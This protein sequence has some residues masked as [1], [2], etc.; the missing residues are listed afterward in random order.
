[1][2]LSLVPGHRKLLPR[3]CPQCG[4]ENGGIQFVF[5]NPRFYKERT[6]YG[7]YS[8]HLLRIS[9]YSREEYHSKKNKNK[10]HKSTKIW[11]NFRFIGEFKIDYGLEPDV[12]VISIEELFDKEDYLDK[13]SV[14]LPM[15]PNRYE[16]IRKYGWSILLPQN[17]GAH[18]FNKDGPKTCQGCNKVVEKLRKCLIWF[19][20]QE[21]YEPWVYGHYIRLCQPCYII[22]EANRLG[23]RQAIHE[24]ISISPSLLPS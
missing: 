19:E 14:T 21:K 7:P 20:E 22:K 3:P 9:H 15:T 6:G 13:Q 11:H 16:G 1:V 8:Y 2:Y 10:K 4:C 23:Q 24:P 12:E 17:D 5:F 18:W